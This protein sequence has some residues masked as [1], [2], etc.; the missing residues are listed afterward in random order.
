MNTYIFSS[1]EELVAQTIADHGCVESL[2][3]GS[4]KPLA[5]ILENMP[6]EYRYW[7]LLRGYSQ[8]EEHCDWAA[9]P[10]DKFFYL[11]KKNPSYAAKAN[12]SLFAPSTQARL[13]EIHPQL[14]E[15]VTTT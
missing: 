15:Y 7:G 8:F 2:V 12:W 11:I 5:Y 10:E 14:A 6:P 1:T 13:A 3:W 4:D 9:I